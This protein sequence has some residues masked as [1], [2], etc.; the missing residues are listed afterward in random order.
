MDPLAR[1]N[2]GT[3]PELLFKPCDAEH[4][5]ECFTGIGDRDRDRNRVIDS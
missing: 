5:D 2:F 3:S 1:Y 4:S